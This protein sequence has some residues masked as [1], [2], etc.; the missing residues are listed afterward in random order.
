M[1]TIKYISYHGMAFVWRA[2][3]I[4]MVGNGN[5]IR[6]SKWCGR[7][8][9]GGEEDHVRT[10]CRLQIPTMDRMQKSFTWQVLLNRLICKGN[11]C[12]LIRVNY[13]DF[14]YNHIELWIPSRTISTP[15]S[16]FAHSLSTINFRPRSRTLNE[17]LKGIGL[18]LKP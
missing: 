13:V 7:L 2:V 16:A 4:S 6:K 18:E 1:T 15:F 12:Q 8:L 3:W 14:I 9:H 10:Q 17:A 5:R 11:Q